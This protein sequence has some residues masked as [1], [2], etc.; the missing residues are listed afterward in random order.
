MSTVAAIGRILGGPKYT[1]RLRSLR[2]LERVVETGLPAATLD[3]VAGYIAADAR[4]AARLRD[5]LVHPS[6]RK[7]KPARLSAEA[8][9][10]IERAARVMAAAEDLWGN[11]GDAQ[12]FVATPHPLL[13][14]RTPMEAARTE[15]G[16][17]QVEELIL[18]TLHGVP[19]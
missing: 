16:A 14:G 15:L 8:S 5:L 4:A 6:T 1:G 7:R 3:E 9:A 19:L 18:R 17:R 2:D 10:R 12:T 11:R 13:D